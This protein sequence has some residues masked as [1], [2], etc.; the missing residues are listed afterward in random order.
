M[1]QTHQI[2]HLMISFVFICN[3]KSP[4][5]FF[6]NFGNALSMETLTNDGKA[7]TLGDLVKNLSILSNWIYMKENYNCDTHVTSNDFL[8]EESSDFMSSVY[9]QDNFS[10]IIIG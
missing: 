5:Q 10:V 2:H 9:D 6:E 3:S 7:E 1:I 8:V 4:D